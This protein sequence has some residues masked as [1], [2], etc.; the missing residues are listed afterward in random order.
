MRSVF[1]LRAAAARHISIRNDVRSFGALSPAVSVVS[2][3]LL[4]A[5][6]ASADVSAAAMLGMASV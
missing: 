3:R 4:S 5:S 1:S 2:R 6:V